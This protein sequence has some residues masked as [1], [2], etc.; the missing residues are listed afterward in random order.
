MNGGCSFR[1]HRGSLLSERLMAGPQESAVRTLGATLAREGSPGGGAREGFRGDE[2]FR[3]DVP[4]RSTLS[5]CAFRRFR[6]RVCH[7]LCSRL[8]PATSLASKSVP[9][10]HPLPG[11]TLPPGAQRASSSTSIRFLG[12][13]STIFSSLQAGTLCGAGPIRAL[14]SPKP[15]AGTRPWPARGCRRT[16]RCLH[17]VRSSGGSGSAARRQRRGSPGVFSAGFR[18]RA[19][20][21][22]TRRSGGQMPV[23][24][25]N[26]RVDGDD[27]AA[28]DNIGPAG[29]R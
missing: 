11:R 24:R 23:S 26:H 19:A 20:V 12:A 15:F 27:P 7:D 25:V 29:C 18:V 10:R 17:S 22:G 5:R 14:I 6:F 16:F 9:R 4:G 21:A 28:R 2:S 1:V 8:T 3:R 13:G